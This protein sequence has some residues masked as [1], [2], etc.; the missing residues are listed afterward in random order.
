MSK[1]NR[2]LYVGLALAALLPLVLGLVL[3]WSAWITVPLFA[4]VITGVYQKLM[5]GTRTPSDHVGVVLDKI[6][7][8]PDNPV[9][10][11]TAHRFA[12]LIEAAGNPRVAEEVRQ[13]F[14]AP[15]PL[16]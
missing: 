8:Y 4:A 12:K 11:L 16:R 5:H 9:R 15:Y 1:E 10:A 3:G 13:K 6:G 14:D 7:L 2:T